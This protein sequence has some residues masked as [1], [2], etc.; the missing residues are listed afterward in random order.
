MDIANIVN[1]IN[2]WSRT[3]GAL[4]GAIDTLA[5]AAVAVNNTL[6][7]VASTLTGTDCYNPYNPYYPQYPTVPVQPFPIGNK[8]DSVIGVVGKAAAGATTGYMLSET[9][10]NIYHSGAPAG[11]IAKGLGKVSLKAAGIG[12]LVSGGVS[13]IENTVK[14]VKKEQSGAEAGGNITADLLG[15]AVSGAAG[16]ALGGLAAARFGGIGGAIAGAAAGI[17]ID[18]L[19]RKSGLKQGLANGVTKL[20]GGQQ[21]YP[22]YPSY[23]PYPGYG[24]P[25][26]R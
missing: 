9:V 19:Y 23:P 16:S 26:A 13:I 24:Y 17:G 4:S 10:S 7:T 18:F 6:N 5:P 21:T 12:A 8:T 1:G 15:G 25:M 14:A 11:E 20:L 2:D 3:I 22:T